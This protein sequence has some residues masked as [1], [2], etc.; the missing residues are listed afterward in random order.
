[1]AHYFPAFIGGTLIDLSA[2][3]A[4]GMVFFEKTRNL[5]KSA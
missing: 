3:F 2:A 1:M 4:Q 5:R